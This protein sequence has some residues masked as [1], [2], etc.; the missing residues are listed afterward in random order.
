MFTPAQVWVFAL[1]ALVAS[2]YVVALGKATG[3]KSTAILIM[4]DAM[5]ERRLRA[6]RRDR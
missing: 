2:V 4:E 1:L 5:R 6:A 3:F